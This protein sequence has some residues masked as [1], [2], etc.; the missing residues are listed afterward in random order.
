LIEGIVT[1][2][3]VPAIEVEVDRQRW[4]AIID[5]G[6]NGE[7]EL[8]ERLRSLVNPQ[9][10]GRATSLLAANQQIEEDLFL[11]DFPFDGRTIRA[12]A[13]FVDGDAPLIGT[14]MLQDYRLRIDFP[15]RTVV[16]EKTVSTRHDQ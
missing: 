9:F 8:P 2:D 1:E 7:L 6:F 5:T 10:V 16:I 15:A 4:Q 3:G 13:T 11:V 12:Q 14:R